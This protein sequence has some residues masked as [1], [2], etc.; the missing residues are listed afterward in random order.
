LMSKLDTLRSTTRR[1]FVPAH[2]RVIR[3][4]MHGWDKTILTE[5][6]RVS[7]IVVYSI[8]NNKPMVAEWFNI[9]SDIDEKMKGL[10]NEID[11]FAR[12]TEFGVYETYPHYVWFI[13]QLFKFPR[14]T[15][16]KFNT[17]TDDTKLASGN[18]PAFGLPQVLL[19]MI[20]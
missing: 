12:E 3:A 5:I 6:Q 1:P 7:Y 11:R 13:W 8:R 4:N 15:V 10:Y 2:E 18:I 16:Q 9:N 14:E 20:T 17:P 19:S